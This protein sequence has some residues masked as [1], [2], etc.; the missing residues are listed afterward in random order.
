MSY[1]E[2]YEI[3]NNFWFNTKRIKPSTL[4]IRT[5]C[6]LCD[7]DHQCFIFNKSSVNEYVLDKLINVLQPSQ[8]GYGN[9]KD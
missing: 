1:D 4:Q 3:G 9:E 7:S 5:Y 8:D 6:I 2:N